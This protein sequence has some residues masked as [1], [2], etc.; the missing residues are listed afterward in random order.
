MASKIKVDTLETANGSGTIALSNQLS[1]MTTA[2]LPALT[3]AQMP[4]GS[5]IQT[6]RAEGS[7]AT[8]TTSSTFANT[9]ASVTI[10]PLFSS[11]DIYLSHT[12]GGLQNNTADM[13]LRITRAIS[14]GATTNIYTS[15]RYGYSD[16][17][18]YHPI[19][20]GVIDVDT[21][22]NTTNA[23]TFKIQINVQSGEARHC[24]NSTW[25][26]VAMEIKR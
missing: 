11:S 6:V 21:S 8:T 18:Y 9:N 1:G 14:G 15:T 16:G 24:D 12:A 2:S 3:G 20:W 10:T 7:T 17:P 25:N 5:V 22:H 23:L 13:G 4:A 19:N 26:F